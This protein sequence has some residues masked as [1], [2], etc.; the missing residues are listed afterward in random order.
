MKVI[1]QQD[2][3]GTGKAGDVVN[4]SDGYARN[5]L[6]KKNLAIE[7][8][9]R[10]LKVLEKKKEKEK[11]QYEADKKAALELKDKLEKGTVTLKA[12]GGEN[13]KLFGSVTSQDIADAIGEQAGIEV[14]KKKIT[15]DEHIKTAGIYAVQIKLFHEV[16][17]KV[18]INVVTM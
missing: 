5:M 3:K 12:K 14:D 10:N 17:A 13:G 4:V 15:L 11:E 1:L 2:V 16:S 7:A 9:D 18:R 6:F 8:T